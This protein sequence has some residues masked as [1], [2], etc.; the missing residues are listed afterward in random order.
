VIDL[1]RLKERLEQPLPGEDAHVIMA[2]NARARS[3]EALKKVSNPKESAVLLLLFPR[4]G[5]T[6]FILI[7][8][9]E[10]PGVHSAQISFPGGKKEADDRS[11]EMT[12]LRETREEVGVPE[13]DI[14]V[15]GKLTPIFIPPSGFYVAPFIGVLDHDPVLTG[16]PD[17]VQYI[18]TPTIDALLDPSTVEEKTITFSSGMR[19]KTPFFNLENE[20][21]WGAT[22]MILSE[23]KEL[24]KQL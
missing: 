5:K 14:N 22:C 8:R 10:Y 2:P 12:A 6:H 19:I 23:F 9:N 16:N 3:S 17:E 24:I 13:S 1:Q 11:L 4:D 7:K 20:V 18:I 21:V 15:L